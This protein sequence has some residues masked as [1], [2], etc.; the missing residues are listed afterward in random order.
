MQRRNASKVVTKFFTLEDGREPTWNCLENSTAI[1][2]Y[3]RP[4]SGVIPPTRVV[5]Y[6]RIVL[7]KP[8]M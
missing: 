4:R 1:V 5:E 7:D 8:G 3:V 6:R 2:E